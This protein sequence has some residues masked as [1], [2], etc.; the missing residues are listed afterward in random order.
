MKPLS[1]AAALISDGDLIYYYTAFYADDAFL[2]ILGD[3]KYLFT[4]MRYYSAAKTEANA[5]VVLLKGNSL[6]D[7]LKEKGVTEIKLIFE[8]TSAAVYDKF[9]KLGYKISDCTLEHDKKAIVKSKNEL[10]LIKKA[11]EIAEEAFNKTLPCIK[12]GV[13]ELEIAALLEY[14]FKLLGASG[15]SFDTI[16]AFNEGSSVPHYKTSNKKLERGSVILMDFGCKYEGYCSDMTRT[17]FFGE[18][19]NEFLSVYEAVKKAH[20]LAF[21]EAKSN[22]K[23]SAV[24]K[25]ARNYLES[26][27]YGENFTHSLGHGIGVKIHEQP[28]LNFRSEQVLEEGMVFSVEPGVYLEGKFGVRLE[29]TVAIIDGKAQSFMKTSLQPIIIR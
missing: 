21:S 17:L 22:V 29:N 26:L 1:N 11:C 13:T 16:V 19:T 25:A 7:F 5:E 6:E 20:E 14:N 2:V 23:A 24:D 27:G 18:P 4:D 15:P 10:E 3:K 12:E 8:C 9:S 28:R